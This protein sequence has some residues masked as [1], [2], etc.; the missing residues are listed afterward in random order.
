MFMNEWY[1]IPGY[2]GYQ[3]NKSTKEVRSFKNYKADPFHMMKEDKNGY[4][5]ISNDISGK[6]RI[7]KN[8]LYDITFNRGEQLYP[9]SSTSVYMGGRQQLAKS[10]KSPVQMDFFKFVKKD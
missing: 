3:I 6:T 7:N 5:V 2:N 9:A 4:V 10:Q 1:F 8:E